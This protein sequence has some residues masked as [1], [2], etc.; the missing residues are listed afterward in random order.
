MGHQY[1]RI[2]LGGSDDVQGL[3]SNVGKRNDI[4]EECVGIDGVL[5][6]DLLPSNVVRGYGSVTMCSDVISINHVTHPFS[7]Y[8]PTLQC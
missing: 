3:D 5:L 4:E 8:L 6:E 1:L 2:S 7:T